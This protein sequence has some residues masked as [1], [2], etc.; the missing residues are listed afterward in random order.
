MSDYQAPLRDIRFI[1]EELAGLRDIGRLPG[2]EE[3]TP[4]LVSVIHD[5]AGKFASGILAPL[6]RVGDRQGCRLEGDRVIMA[7]GW[8]EAYRQ[9]VADGWVDL[10]HFYFGQLA[11]LAGGLA[12]IVMQ[13]GGSVVKPGEAMF[14]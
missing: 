12:S 8:R 14:G 3:A 11:P 13:G 2:C 5:Q 1:L 4:D 9:F 10:V 6:N 7:E